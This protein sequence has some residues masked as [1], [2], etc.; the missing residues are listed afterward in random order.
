M[1]AGSLTTAGAS[2][3]NPYLAAAGFAADMFGGGSETSSAA[4]SLRDF[5][6]PIN[7]GDYFGG[8]V[9]GDRPEVGIS[10]GWLVG[11]GVAGLFLL[12]IARGR[13]GK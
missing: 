13:R 12:L 11:G 1:Q 9:V 3:G 10:P 4:V 7:F 6:A 2:T 8:S 5:L